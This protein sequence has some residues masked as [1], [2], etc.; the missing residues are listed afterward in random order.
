VNLP[1][2]IAPPTATELR[3]RVLYQMNGESRELSAADQARRKRIT[4]SLKTARK[5]RPR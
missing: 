4:H 3:D 5:G 1:K 2:I